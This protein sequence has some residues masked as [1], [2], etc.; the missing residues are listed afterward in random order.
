MNEKRIRFGS[1]TLNH[2]I[3]TN[4]GEE[5]IR[6]EIWKSKE[7]LEQVL[8]K[9]VKSF[10]YPNGNFREDI[11]RI[12][13]QA[14]YELAFTCKPGL[15]KVSDDPYRLKRKLVHEKVCQDFRG[16]YSKALFALF[17]SS[18]VNGK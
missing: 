18:L 12:V 9:P 10:C 16:A 15:V 14:G 2:V 8:G 17:V 13:K 6:H 11:V 1:H 7:M 3:L 4:E 5:R